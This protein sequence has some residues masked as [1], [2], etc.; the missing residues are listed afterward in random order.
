MIACKAMS[1]AKS[2]IPL[3]VMRLI[4]PLETFQTFVMTCNQYF[5]SHTVASAEAWQWSRYG[6]SS[7]H[8]H[9]T[10]TRKGP[11]EE[12]N[13]W[14]YHA[15]L[16]LSTVNTR[17]KKSAIVAHVKNICRDNHINVSYRIAF[18]LG[19]QMEKKTCFLQREKNAESNSTLSCPVTVTIN[20]NLLTS[21]CYH[22]S[23]SHAT[24]LYSRW[25]K[26]QGSSGHANNKNYFLDSAGTFCAS[27]HCWHFHMRLDVAGVSESDEGEVRVGSRL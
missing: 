18:V 23:L 9:P 5:S 2:Q 11:C 27:I 14:L 25:K 21:I 6:P 1:A 7:V 24:D 8:T 13:V 3:V 26:K 20:D 12:V 22:G 19:W 17:S 10:F 16:Y 15:M 4:P